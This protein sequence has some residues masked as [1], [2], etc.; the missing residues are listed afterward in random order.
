MVLLR[1][2]FDIAGGGPETDAF[3]HLAAAFTVLRSLGTAK[4][5]ANRESSRIVSVLPLLV[6]IN[7]L[8]NEFIRKKGVIS[9]FAKS[10]GHKFLLIFVFEGSL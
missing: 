7:E 6:F 2:L 3:K 10:N 4:T 1:Q 5:A 9:E 8:M